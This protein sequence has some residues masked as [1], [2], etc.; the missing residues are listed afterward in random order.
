MAEYPGWS[1]FGTKSLRTFAWKRQDN[2]LFATFSED[3]VPTM[4]N[5]IF[6]SMSFFGF[7]L[8][9]FFMGQSFLFSCSLFFGG[10]VGAALCVSTY[11]L[12]FDLDSKQ[13]VRIVK[14]PLLITN[15]KQKFPF[16]RFGS[17]AAVSLHGD[18]QNT[19]ILYAIRKNRNGLFGKRNILAIYIDMD[20][21]SLIGPILEE[22][23]DLTGWFHSYKR[24]TAL[25]Y[26]WFYFLG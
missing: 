14:S 6:A 8:A 18:G 19:L 22:I 7:G 11:S 3:D 23:S 9:A 10:Y 25:E 16:D 12:Q 17:V 1:N 24:L 13:L 15:S 5:Y 21:L 26:I 20:H 2:S 4:I